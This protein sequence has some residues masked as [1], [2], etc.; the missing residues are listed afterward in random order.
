[1]CTKNKQFAAENLH[2]SILNR[3]ENSLVD[4]DPASYYV[5]GCKNWSLFRKH[6]FDLRKYCETTLKGRIPTKHE[7]L[8]CLEAA[9]TSNDSTGN[10][11]VKQSKR[12]RENPVC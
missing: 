2:D 4:A 12:A 7:I 11:S 9:L 5:S 6:V 3:L 10:V 8:N 1:L